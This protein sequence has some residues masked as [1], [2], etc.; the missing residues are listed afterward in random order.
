MSQT[1]GPWTVDHEEN[2]S[3]IRSQDGFLIAEVHQSRQWVVT[4]EQRKASARLIAAA[5]DLLGA[6]ET[7]RDGLADTGSCRSQRMTIMTK[8]DAY[9][10]AVKALLALEQKP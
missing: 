9:L 6:L 7:I 2:R 4:A 8:T 1:S 5:P 10:V 3:A